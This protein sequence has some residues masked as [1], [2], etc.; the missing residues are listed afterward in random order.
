MAGRRDKVTG[1]QF[2]AS[3]WG[4]LG[5]CIFCWELYELNCTEY[6]VYPSTFVLRTRVL[7]MYELRQAA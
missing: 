7:A 6:G 2:R 4:G 1:D 3:K 5:A